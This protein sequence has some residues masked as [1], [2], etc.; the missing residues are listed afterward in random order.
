MAVA[1]HRPLRWLS[2]IRKTDLAEVGGKGANLG[3]LLAAGLPVPSAFVVCASAFR[4][5]LS[6]APWQ[7]EIRTLPVRAASASAAEL[8]ALS[9]DAMARIRAVSVPAAMREEVTQAYRELGKDAPVAVRSSAIGED[10]ERTSFAGMHDSF[11]GV[12]GDD[13]LWDAIRACWASAYGARALVYRAAQHIEDEPCVAVVVQRMVHA[14]RAGVLFS[15]DPTTKSTDVMV[16]EAALGFG[17]VVVSGAVEPDRYVAD[18]VTGALRDW[19]RGVQDSMLRW[20]PG[21]GTRSEPLGADLRSRRVLSDDDVAA[22]VRLGSRITALYGA[23][24]DVEWA[25]EGGRFYI[26]QSRP[27]TQS[28]HTGARVRDEF[29]AEGEALP[30]RPTAPAQAAG[31][32][33]SIAPPPSAPAGTD[34]SARRIVGLAA[35][36]GRVSG[37]ARI[38]MRPEEGEALLDG[39]ILVAPMTAPDWL[40]TLRR[41]AAVVTERGGLTCHAAI[42]SR[43][44]GIPA[45]VGAHDATRL[46]HE[47][48]TITVDGGRGWVLFG[49]AA[50]EAAPGPARA[51]A[52]AA[53]D[54]PS[55]RGPGASRAGAAPAGQSATHLL[56]NV[57]MADQ[58]EGAARLPVDGVGLLRAEFLYLDAL[59]HRH[60]GTW[61]RAGRTRDLIERLKAPVQRIAQAFAPR[62]VV[63]R[64]YDFRTHEFR[65]LEEGER[66]EAVEANPMIGFRGCFRYAREPALFDAELVM[67]AEVRQESPNLEVMLPFA[68]TAWEVEACLERIW[69]SPLASQR[70]LRIWLMAEVPSVA[71]WLPAY[72]RLGVHGV[73]IGSNDLTQLML[74][75]DRDST[76]CAALFDERDG[77]VLDAIQRIVRRARAHGL[78]TSICGEAPSRD[79]SF[80]AELVALG[81]E[82][83]SVNPDAVA[84]AQ[85]AILR[86]EHQLLVQ[87]AREHH[88]RKLRRHRPDITGRGARPRRRLGGTS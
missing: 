43:E 82:S 34:T 28:A 3:E 52:P 65:G 5:A 8:R 73:S 42:V 88:E 40:P 64:T 21:E 57:S 11:V 77:A 48:Q 25:E 20:S 66:F 86:A 47:G 68:R 67:L 9:A 75:V 29:L 87:A 51:V 26:V 41:A 50:S 16:I 6:A 61:L 69:R 80:I 4:E 83:I 17:E 1:N 22:L 60:P 38:L 33:Q 32:K 12:T 79:P 85:A 78:K 58:A 15:A 19:H 35:S 37:R 54:T 39:E 49:D 14:A 46:L 62:P 53:D 10:T 7:D 30:A 72:A 84:T 63:Y 23:P 71:Y 44:L 18:A 45:V 74:G 27:I 56:V 70:G 13:A 36:P 81:I 55:M 31:A 2:Q 76:T 59:E 24:Q